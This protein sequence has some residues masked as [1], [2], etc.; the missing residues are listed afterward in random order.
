MQIVRNQNLGKKERN[1][2]QKRK[3][4]K[5][6][7]PTPTPTPHFNDTRKLGP[8]WELKSKLDAPK[9]VNSGFVPQYQIGRLLNTLNKNK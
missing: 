8:Q 2:T 9:S 7:T 5:K 6:E 3:I 1:N 4:Y